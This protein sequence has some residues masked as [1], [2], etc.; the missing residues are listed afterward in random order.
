[1]LKFHRVAVLVILC[2]SMVGTAWSAELT[3]GS[4]WV[5]TRGSTVTFTGVGS[6]G[7]LEGYYINQAAGF[8]CQNTRYSMVGWSYESIITFT[9]IWT[10]STENCNSITSWTGF[11]TSS[12]GFT[13]L[14]Q[15]VNSGTTNPG[16]ILQGSDTFTLQ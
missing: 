1:M 4:T 6:D 10:N 12:S 16:Q 3:A 13:T 11:L 2:L 15:L 9:V 5:N 8:G 14:W 7:H